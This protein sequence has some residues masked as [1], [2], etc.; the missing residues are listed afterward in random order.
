MSVRNAVKGV[1]VVFHLSSLVGRWQSE[2]P[3][4]EFNRVNVNGTKILMAECQRE[5]V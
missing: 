3:Q 5:G 4:S 1:N 2:Y